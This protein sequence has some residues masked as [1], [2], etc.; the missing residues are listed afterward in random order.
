LLDIPLANVLADYVLSVGLA[1]DVVVISP[2]NPPSKFTL[3]KQP[4]IQIHGVT[5]SKASEF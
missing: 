5:L 3:S 2:E 4:E 1:G